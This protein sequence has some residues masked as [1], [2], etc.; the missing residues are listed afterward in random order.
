MF[1]RFTTGARAVVVDSQDAARFL[2]HRHIGTEHLLL[3]LLRD[4][5]SRARHALHDS[6]HARGSYRVNSG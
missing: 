5:D 2:G 6:S 3:G 1:E 4:D